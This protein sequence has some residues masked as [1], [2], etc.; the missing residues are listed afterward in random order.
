MAAAPRLILLAHMGTVPIGP[1]WS[2]DTLGGEVRD[3]RL[4]GRGAADMKAGL[5]VGLNAIEAVARGPAHRVDVLPC[6]TVDEEGP[7]MAGAHA[8]VASRLL[9][10]DDQLLG[11]EPTALR[12]RIAQMGLRWLELTAFGKMAHAGRAPL[13]VDANHLTAR[14]VDHLKA[15]VKALP[16]HDPLLGR[17]LLTCGRIEGGIATNVV[18][19]LCTARL[20][21]RL[22]PPLDPED[23]VEL[24]R[25][26]VEETIG[27]FAGAS[28]ELRPL[29]VAWP[30]VRAAEDAPVVARLR[31]AYEA[32]TG[33]ALE[34]GDAEGHEA[35]TDA[36][37]VAALTGSTSCTVFGPGSS[38][39]AHVVDEY[40]VD[41]YV[42]VEDLEAASL[43]LE[44]LVGAW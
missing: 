42:A 8:L 23:M 20:D 34:S 18:L 13:G 11:V 12:L 35:Y 28:Y 32:V 43:V 6:A 39:R 21:L 19:P 33:C 3:G 16:Y 31:A 14:I 15:R 30:P 25:V 38:N 27:E 36:S 5:A 10:P 40:V 44:A 1:G 2:V 24:A 7:E 17:P 26:V 41:E 4:Y 37:M 29:W 22:A 9:R